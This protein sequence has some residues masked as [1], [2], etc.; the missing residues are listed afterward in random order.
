MGGEILTREPV[1]TVKVDVLG[2]VGLGLKLWFVFGLGLRLGLG[3]VL[4][5]LV[6]VVVVVVVEAEAETDAEGVAEAIGGRCHGGLGE[7]A[8]ES[9]EGAS[10]GCRMTERWCSSN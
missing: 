4:L 5:L 9:L 7:R 3:E 8:L 1:G 2:P 6:V 10:T